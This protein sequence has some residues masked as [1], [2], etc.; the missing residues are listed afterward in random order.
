MNV[1]F[2]S[3]DLLLIRK[4][5]ESKTTVINE[6]IRAEEGRIYFCEFWK[7]R[8]SVPSTLCKQFLALFHGMEN[9]EFRLKAKRLPNEKCIRVP[10]PGV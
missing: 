9:S 5:T 10:L 1:Q 6:G 4:E 8:H 2:V 7:E 3:R